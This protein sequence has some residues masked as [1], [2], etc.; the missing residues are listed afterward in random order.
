MCIKGLVGLLG[1]G[2]IGA[3]WGLL[4]YYGINLCSKGLVG[5]LGLIGELV[6][7]RC[8]MGLIGMLKG[9]LRS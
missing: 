3:L 6:I 5:V 1:G 2:V 9:Y 4:V 7:N 8:I